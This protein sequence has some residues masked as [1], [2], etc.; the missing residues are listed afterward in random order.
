[1]TSL[2]VCIP[3]YYNHLK[4]L[5]DVLTSIANQTVK[6]SLIS[7]SISSIP[8]GVSLD[9]PTDITDIPLHVSQT[10]NTQ[11]AAENREAAAQASLQYEH[12]EGIVFFDVDDYMHPL[13]LEKV[14]A[15]FQEGADVFLH[16]YCD[17]PGR[18]QSP[19]EI[20][21]EAR[22]T[23]PTIYQAYFEDELKPVGFGQISP[24]DDNS[25]LMDIANGHVSIKRFVYER[26]KYNYPPYKGRGEDCNYNYRLL[27]AGYNILASKDKLSLYFW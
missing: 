13:Y 16:D 25:K 1:M 17:W 3:A 5:P 2:A 9:L 14:Q 11:N 27:K 12:V 24:Y 21:K 6:P 26:E 18:K 19:L 20:C 4:Y 15:A 22:I 7:I 23:E 8:T 10:S